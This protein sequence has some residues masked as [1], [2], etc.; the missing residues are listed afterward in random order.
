MLKIALIG[1][2]QM[3][4][5]LERLAPKNGCEVVAIIDP[6]HPDYPSEITPETLKDASVCIEFTQPGAVLDN[7]KAIAACGRNMVIGTTG[8]KLDEAKLDQ[9]QIGMVHG[10][11]FSVGMNAMYMIVEAAA[12]IMNALPEYDPYG[13]ELH[14]RLKKD[15]P[16]GTAKTL[17]QILLN[18]ID[19]KNR[20]EFDKLDRE[21]EVDELHFSSTRAGSI[22]GEHVIGFDSPADSVRIVHTA[23]NREGFA[24]GAL[25]A[26]KWI[27][28][29]TGIYDFREI[30]R[31]LVI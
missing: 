17:A 24:M 19:R 6:H 16:S 18:R 10:S 31:E 21:I 13:Y 2:G 26:A 3:G 23:R 15:S 9:N 20:C 25:R 27:D 4:K 11:N 22:P 8:W 30:F 14:H 29:V 7:I 5:I 28:G 12:K 1:Y